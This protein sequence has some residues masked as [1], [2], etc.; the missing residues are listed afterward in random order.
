MS[1]P[2]PSRARFLAL[3]AVLA[4]F[5]LV[6]AIALRSEGSYEVTAVFDDV[7][8]L[9]EGGEVKAGGTDV[10]KVEEITFSEDGYPEVRMRIDS[11]FRLEQGAFANIR[12]ASNVG[13]INRFV[14]LTQGDG[15]AL[16]DG[17]TLGPSHTDHPVDFDVAT[18]TLDPRTRAA[19]GKLLANLD[20]ATRGRGPDIARTLRR[21]SAALGETANLLAQ[22]NADGIALRGL[23]ADSRTVVSALAESP[24]ALGDSAE[25]L[26]EVLGLAAI[27]QA[28]LGR[29]AEA[30]GPGLAAARATLERFA[31]STPNL[32]ELVEAAR[33]AVAELG[34]T[35]R[36]LRPA[37]AALRPVA[38]SARRIAAGLGDQLRAL[39]PV[40]AAALPVVRRLPAVLGGLGPL[41]DHMRARA[42]EVVNFFTLAGDATSNYDA[43]GNLI[44]ASAIFIQRPRHPNL[45]DASSDAAGSLVRPF[46]RNPGVAEGEPWEGYWKTF[47][48]GGAPPRSFIEPEEEGP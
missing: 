39:R 20:A 22:V 47:V 24:A 14:D 32:R 6:L 11:D 1:G 16:A 48:G 38:S 28:E 15:P 36:A 46:D 13:A 3:G 10:G 31:A 27:R 12:L 4:A 35:A 25:R 41:L 17:A 23:V 5:F 44:R 37:M 2:A 43:N 18:S 34:P 45:I 29:T 7:R 8:G 42:P 40:I 30:I 33:P 26:A 21:G 9:I 19:A